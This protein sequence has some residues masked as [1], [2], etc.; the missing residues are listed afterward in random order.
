[1]PK[2]ICKICGNEFEGGRVGAVICSTECRKIAQRE[3]ARRWYRD[4]QEKANEQRRMQRK[5]HNN[6][7]KSDT[8]VAIGYAERQVAQTLEMAGRVKI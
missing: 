5:M 2:C 8:I 4:N 3:Y 6:E 7:I 1:M